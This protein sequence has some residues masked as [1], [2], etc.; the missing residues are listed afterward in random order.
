[1]IE[2]L[3]IHRRSANG[4]SYAYWKAN[5]DKIHF[6]LSIVDDRRFAFVEIP[7]NASHHYLLTQR[8]STTGQS[9][10][11]S[12]IKHADPPDQRQINA[13]RLLACH[14]KD[15]R[16]SSACRIYTLAASVCL[17]PRHAHRDSPGG[18]IC[19]ATSVH[20][21]PTIRRTD[22][23]VIVAMDFDLYTVFVA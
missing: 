8:R 18:S 14:G 20:F 22:I 12:E 7:R 19:D 2:E 13:K 3:L 11:R 10:T 23:L 1:M 15:R 5:V 4:E 16:L 17:S 6:R 21:G 9:A